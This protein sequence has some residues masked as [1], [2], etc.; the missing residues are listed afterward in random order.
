MCLVREKAESKLEL[1]PKPCDVQTHVGRH[2]G[3]TRKSSASLADPD[4]PRAPRLDHQ[5]TF[6]QSIPSSSGISSEKLAEPTLI[7]LATALSAPSLRA[8]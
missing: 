3:I 8:A 1:P 5:K 2:R 6:N 4:G 7:L